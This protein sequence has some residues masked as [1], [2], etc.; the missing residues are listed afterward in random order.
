MSER[1]SIALSFH[2]S[3]LN[4]VLKSR[5]LP[6]GGTGSRTEPKSSW[7]AEEG[8]ICD[9]ESLPL[10]EL[11]WEMSIVTSL[12]SDEVWGIRKAF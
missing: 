12:D 4:S 7:V 5:Q 9:Q 3:K 6:P 10:R 8:L 2:A 11:G 1:S